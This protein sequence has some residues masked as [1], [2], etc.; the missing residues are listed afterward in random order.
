MRK[1]SGSLF[2]VLSFL[3]FLSVQPAFSQSV[4]DLKALHKE[5]DGLKEGQAG[6][7]KEIRELKKL[8]DPKSAA[9][10]DD[11][12]K[13]AIINIQGAPMKGDKNAKL[14]FIEF[15]DYQ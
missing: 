12:I 10:P 7:K 8:L 5:I 11:E 13:D 6:I 4:E 15:S 14:V 3:I 9:A 2:F 1:Y